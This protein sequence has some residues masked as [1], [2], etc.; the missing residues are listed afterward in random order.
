MSQL[1]PVYRSQD[2]VGD[3][4]RHDGFCQIPPAHCACSV[5]QK[6]CRTRDA[7]AIRSAALVEEIVGTDDFG[8][9]VGEKHERVALLVAIL[10]IDFGWIDA[11]GNQAHV[12]GLKLLEVLFETPQL[13]VAQC[14]PVAAVEDEQHR[15]GPAGAACA[16]FEQIGKR[17]HLAILV[18]QR[19]IRRL[20][21]DSRR[22][23]RSR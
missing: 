23:V 8:L 2:L 7:L 14:S 6:L 22:P 11:D 12:A 13:G 16:G 1:K 9:R 15:A 18:R 19:E 17:D 21:T 10:A 20:L 4:A 5:D 3:G